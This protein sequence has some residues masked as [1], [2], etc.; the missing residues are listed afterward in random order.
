MGPSPSQKSTL[1]MLFYIDPVSNASCNQNLK[2]RT[3]AMD[4][5]TSAYSVYACE[6]YDN[7]G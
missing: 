4:P 2:K 5:S 3:A 6:N 7:S 1:K